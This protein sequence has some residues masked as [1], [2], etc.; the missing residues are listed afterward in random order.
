MELF[1]NRLSNTSARLRSGR[2]QDAH[3]T[4]VTASSTVEVTPRTHGYPCTDAYTW[5][6]TQIQTETCA[7]T[8]TYA[9]ACE[10]AK[11]R[12]PHT[13]TQT[14]AQTHSHTHTQTH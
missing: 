3:T 11:N 10:R 1:P 4:D 9:H 13:Q 12:Q 7:Y 2:V 5:R 14:Q 8:H 6:S